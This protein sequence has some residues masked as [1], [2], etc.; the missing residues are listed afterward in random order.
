MVPTFAQDDITTPNATFSEQ[1]GELCLPT[2]NPPSHNKSINQ[3][4]NLK[5]PTMFNLALFL[6]STA[7]IYSL[8]TEGVSSSSPEGISLLS[9]VSIRKSSS[10]RTL[11]VRPSKTQSYSIDSMIHSYYSYNWSN[12]NLYVQ[13]DTNFFKTLVS[14]FS[15]TI[16]HIS[17]DQVRKELGNFNIFHQSLELQQ[18]KWLEKLSLM[19]CDRGP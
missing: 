17:Y 16:I 2:L 14:F 12:I 7:S 8:S 18:A 3:D 11:L 5:L 19:R 13:R 9:Q 4:N 15:K 10:C 6:P 1:D